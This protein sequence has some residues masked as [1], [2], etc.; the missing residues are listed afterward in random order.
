MYIHHSINVK[1]EISPPHLISAW[2]AHPGV[3]HLVPVPASLV[4]VVRGLVGGHPHQL[5]G[6]EG[7][8][9]AVEVVQVR[10]GIRTGHYTVSSLLTLTVR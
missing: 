7:E 1:T 4:V 5:R 6:R 8:E 9:V 2:R 3:W 10:P